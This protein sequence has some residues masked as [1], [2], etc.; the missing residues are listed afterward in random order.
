MT[1]L[2]FLMVFCPFSV[3]IASIK[4]PHVIKHPLSSLL[5]TVLYICPFTLAQYHLWTGCWRNTSA[6][7]TYTT[8]VL[9]P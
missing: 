1:S 6:I 9:C 5:V 7:D 4:Y 3:C 2:C 8:K